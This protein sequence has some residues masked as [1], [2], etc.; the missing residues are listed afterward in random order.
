MGSLFYYQF[1]FAKETEM[2]DIILTT[3]ACEIGGGEGQPENGSLG[4]DTQKDLFRRHQ[5]RCKKP[6]VP[7]DGKL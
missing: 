6:G 7:P 3:G 1:L 5:F 4:L 2:A